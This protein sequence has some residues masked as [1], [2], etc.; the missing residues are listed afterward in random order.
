MDAKELRDLPVGTELLVRG[1]KIRG[2]TNGSISLELE[3]H[4]GGGDGDS[5]TVYPSEVE[6]VAPPKPEPIRVGDTVV[7]KIGGHRFYQVLGIHDEFVWLKTIRGMD[8]HFVDDVSTHYLID[9]K[10]ADQ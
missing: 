6:C 9:Y 8:Q 5:I 2:Y 3:R 4:G 7:S 1:R 10:R